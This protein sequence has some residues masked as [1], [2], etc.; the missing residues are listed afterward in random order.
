ML[1]SDWTEWKQAEL[2]QLDAYQAKGMFGLPAVPP[3]MHPSFIKSGFI[4]SRHKRT[5]ERK[6]KVSVTAHLV[7]VKP[8]PSVTLMLQCPKC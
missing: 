8:Q 5:T 3:S 2:K 6:P 4:A 1:Q 7:E